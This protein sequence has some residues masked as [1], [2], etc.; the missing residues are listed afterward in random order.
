MLA[1]PTFSNS[2]RMEGVLDI[3]RD[4]ASL[5]HSCSRLLTPGGVI[6][7]ITHFRR[8]KMEAPSSLSVEDLTRTVPPDFARDPRFHSVWKLSRAT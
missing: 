8:F 3:Q 7:F 5:L 4:H 2:K 1:P 6:Y